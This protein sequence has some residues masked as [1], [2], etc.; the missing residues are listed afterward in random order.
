MDVDNNNHNDIRI[1]NNNRN[2][3]FDLSYVRDN[4]WID[5][6]VHDGLV[7]DWHLLEKLWEYSLQNFIKVDIKETPIL[8]AEKPYNSPS[9]RQK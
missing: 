4:M 6:P 7:K 3:H 8:I 2:V 5:N 1:K 9:S